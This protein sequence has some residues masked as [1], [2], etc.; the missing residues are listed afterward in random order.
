MESPHEE[1]NT[2]APEVEMAIRLDIDLN[3]ELDLLFP[4]IC[5]LSERFAPREQL[6]MRTKSEQCSESC[7]ALRSRFVLVSGKATFI[8]WVDETDEA[9]GDSD[10][11]P[12]VLRQFLPRMR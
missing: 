3:F 8:L 5:L 1:A 10:V 6:L 7:T 11:R 4:L 2:V 12:T 9:P